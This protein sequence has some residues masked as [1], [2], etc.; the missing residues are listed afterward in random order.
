[1]S[2]VLIVNP[3]WDTLG[4]GE[5]YV[6]SFAKLMLG[7]GWQVDI[8]NPS[9]LSA[10]ILD[11]F[12]IDLTGSHWLAQPYKDLISKIY[13]LTFW[14]SDGSLPVS[15][16]PK[17]VIHMQF[18]FQNVGGG[19][20]TN[21]LKTRLYTFVVNSNFT[22][23]FID[24][25]FHIN[26]R[27]VYPPVAAMEITK[28]KKRNLI[29]YAGR[30]SNLAQAKGQ[31]VLV[32]VFKKIS[33]KLPGWKLVLTGGTNVGADQGELQKLRDS[34][35]GFPIQIITDPP[36]PELKKL[37]SETKIFWSASG[38]GINE[39]ADPTR[40]EHFGITVVEAMTAGAV[41]VITNLGGHK[42]I[43]TSGADGY[44]WNTPEELAAQT[45]KLV[46]DKTLLNQLSAQA[47]VRSKIFD[48]G[49][50]NA[51]FKSLLKL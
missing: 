42:E 47:L 2:K 13:D 29:L 50:F 27:V 33:K 49:H 9:N 40:V 51:G 44:L 5:R 19:K 23:T 34:T 20:L 7:C 43:I 6:V 36:Y 46:S 11:R 12:G 41:P 28:A 18:P 14:L 4:G 37:F 21:F 8:L 35:I 10:P 31:P 30:F 38:F 16:S 22:K 3:Y 26:S 1:M 32:D 45:L 15:F 48:I 25:E 39:A 17:T 24:R